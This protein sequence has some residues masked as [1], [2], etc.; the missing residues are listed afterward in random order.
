MEIDFWSTFGHERV[1]NILS[2][3]LKTGKFSHAYLFFGPE[4]IGKKTL[5]EELTG[6]I[7]N[8]Q[9]LFSHPDFIFLDVTSETGIA[10][11]REFMGRLTGKP[12]VGKHKV[13]VINNIQD[14]NLASQNALLKTLEEPSPST[15]LVLIQNGGMI[16]KTILSRC[17][18]F[19]FSTFAGS[20]MEAF[21]N[22]FKYK[23]TKEILDLSFERPG[24][25]VLLS[26]N[27]DFFKKQEEEIH[28]FV[29]I[30]KSLIGERLF[31]ISEFAKMEY[32]EIQKMLLNWLNFQESQSRVDYQ[33]ISGTKALAEALQALASNQNKKL[34][35]QELFFKI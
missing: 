18:I 7:L 21:A 12:F 33:A 2:K 4:N 17:Q 15:I 28:E 35:F 3:Q 19:N 16:V 11:V 29:D 24:R 20:E 23:C 14:L 10:E 30:K 31:K 6:K 25:L 5:A 26:T 9:N 34:I 13:A 1:K 8:E 32:D 27:K 22:F